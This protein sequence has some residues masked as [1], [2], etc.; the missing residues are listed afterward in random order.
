MTSSK[1]WSS[2]IGS[3]K[4]VVK[5]QSLISPVHLICSSSFLCC[6]L[7]LNMIKPLIVMRQISPALRITPWQ[8][9]V[10]REI[11]SQL[12]NITIAQTY[13]IDWYHAS[14]KKVLRHGGRP[15]DALDSS[16]ELSMSNTSSQGAW[17]KIESKLITE[18][19]IQWSCSITEIKQNSWHPGNRI[20]TSLK[21]SGMM[22][23]VL[24]TVTDTALVHSCNSWWTI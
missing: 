17:R 12:L 19:N 4:I 3:Q 1:N 8:H 15:R 2:K 13:K 6:L 18:A 7:Y 24:S 9:F 21:Y 11:V 20:K 16:W 22:G 23:L 14:F 10:C 5:L